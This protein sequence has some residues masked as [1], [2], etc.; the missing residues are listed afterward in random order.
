MPA[1]GYGCWKIPKNKMAVGTY[2]AIKTGYRLID[3]A[4][5]HCNEKECGEGIAKALNEGIVMREELF[6]T[7][8]LW[9]THHSIHDVKLACKKN[10]ADLGVDYLDLYMVHF[11]VATRNVPHDT[12]YPVFWHDENKV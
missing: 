7:S 10:M 8:K 4:A 2:E 3:Q 9:N 1:V 12:M 6:I 11:P 5:V